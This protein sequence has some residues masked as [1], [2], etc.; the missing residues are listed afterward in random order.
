M[1]RI[2]EEQI[3]QRYCKNCG[4]PLQHSYNHQCPY[5]KTLYDFNAPQ[6]QVVEVK[7]EDLVDVELKWIEQGFLHNSLILMF[8]GY[9]CPMPKVYEYND[10]DNIYI[11]QCENYINPPKCGFCIEIPIHEIEKYGIDYVFHRI[12]TTGLRYNELKKV[13]DQIFSNRT[14]RKYSYGSDKE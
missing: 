10:E 8:D 5:C 14:L 2:K 6:E 3:E 1:Q 12:M 13:R 7:P 4:S 11:S 9:K